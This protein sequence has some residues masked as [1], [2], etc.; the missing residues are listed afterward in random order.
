MATR[1][2]LLRAM[3]AHV[4]VAVLCVSLRFGMRMYWWSQC[5]GKPSGVAYESLVRQGLVDARPT[6]SNLPSLGRLMAC[7]FHLFICGAT[8]RLQRVR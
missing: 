5:V 3:M 1:G 8:T 2:L 4:R 6:K 7:F